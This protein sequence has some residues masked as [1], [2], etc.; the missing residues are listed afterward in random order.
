MTAD[1]GT[2]RS[3]SVGLCRNINQIPAFRRHIHQKTRW[4]KI[5][6]HVDFTN[7]KGRHEDNSAHTCDLTFNRHQTF[8]SS[9]PTCVLRTAALKPCITTRSDRFT[10]VQREP[11]PRPY[12]NYTVY[13]Q[14]PFREVLLDVVTIASEVEY[15]RPLSGQFMRG[16]L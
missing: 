13:L 9:G 2:G 14:I 10:T 4:G 1:T 7:F 3:P 8:S 6:R 16:D 5:W 15:P 12:Y 11:P